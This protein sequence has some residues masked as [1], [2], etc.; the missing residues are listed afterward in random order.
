MIPVSLAAGAGLALIWQRYEIRRKK[1]S[2]PSL[3]AASPYRN[4][5]LLAIRLALKAGENMYKYCDEAGTL[6]AEQH[7]LGISEKSKP[8]DFFTKID[9]ENETLV[10][11]GIQSAFP[12]DKIIGE[13]MVG[14]GSIPP[15]TKDPTWII[16]PIDGTTSF[17]SG[18][19]LTCVSIG[20]CFNGVPVMGVVSH[21]QIAPLM[22]VNA[23]GDA[24]NNLT[25]SLFFGRCMHP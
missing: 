22:T 21:A 9:V 17:A 13:E 25:I 3:I 18:L 11:E 6:A 2:I 19:P 14:T 16:D 20:Y 23:L 15:L 7:D 1:Y 12:D 4:Q 8:E 24:A 5:V 10:M